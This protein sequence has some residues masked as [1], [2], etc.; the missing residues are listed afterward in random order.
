MY[1]YRSAVRTLTLLLAL[2]GSAR[3]QAPL[4]TK[5]FDRA[6]LDTTCA[7]CEDFYEFANGSWLKNAKIPADYS[8]YGAFDQ[9]FDQNQAVL[10]N[11]L[12]TSVMRVESGQYKPGT[13]EW[14]VGTFYATCMDTSAIERMGAKPLAAGFARIAAINSVDDL[15][16]A[17]GQLEKSYGLAPISEGSAQ[18]AKDAANT[19]AGLYQG[20]LSLPNSEYYTKTDTA[21][22]NL[23]NKFTASVSRMF[24]L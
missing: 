11:V 1:S 21:S 8:T 22:V 2:A 14:K 13:G 12:D 9:L 16:R 4:Q 24:Q 19:I 15:K 7:P 17:F 3:A 5:P 10:R 23:R 20:G 6:N 18:D